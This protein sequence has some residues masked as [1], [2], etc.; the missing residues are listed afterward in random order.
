MLENAR[1]VCRRWFGE[2]YDLGAIDST[3]STAA[4]ERLNGDP[5]WLL[6][7]SGSGNAKTE[8][9]QAL[10]GAGAF[11][12]STISSEGAFLSGTAPKEKSPG[13]TG[14]LLKRIGTSG[15]LVIK[16]FTSILAMNRDARSTVMAALREIHDGRWERNL[17]AGGGLTLT[18]EGRIA[19]VGAVTTSWDQHHNVISQLG[20]RF[21][22]LRMDSGKGRLSA[23][24]R[25]IRNTGEEGQMRQDLSDA[26][27]LVLYNLAP[28]SPVTEAEQERILAAADVVTRVRTGVEFDY[29]G[30]VIDAHAPEMPTRFA[31]QLT[32]MF[33][34]ALAIGMDRPEALRLA[35]RCA[36]DSM[37]PLRLAILEDVAAHPGSLT[38]EVRQRLDKPRATVDRQLQALH[39]LRVLTCDEEESSHRG[40]DVTLWRYRLVEGINPDALALP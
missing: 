39:A 18:W 15:V 40:R 23:G 36:R 38:S 19:V 11:V 28:D 5:L 2:G 10:A 25:A 13:A 1:N 3:L 22:I 37:P 4:A 17:G 27:E 26:V 21:V 7:I 14:G 9:C 29:R 35:I 24:R 6:M 32:Q 34:G 30:E 33:R 31:K 16:D 8:T 12:T 20:D